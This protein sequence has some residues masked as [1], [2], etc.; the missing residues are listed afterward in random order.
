MKQWICADMTL[1][2]RFCPVFQ[3]E[4]DLALPVKSAILEICGLGLYDLRVNGQAPDDTL[5]NPGLTQYSVSVKYRRYELAS[6][7]RPGRNTLHVELGHGFFNENGGVW[8]WQTAA[9]RS[10]PRLS[11]ELTLTFPDSSKQSLCT[12]ESWLY[13]KDG[14]TVFNSVYA[15]ETHDF[16]LRTPLWKKSIPCDPPM[17]KPSLQQEPFIRKTEEYRPVSVEKTGKLRYL[18]TSPETVTGWARIRFSVPCTEGTEIT[19]TYGEQIAGSELLKCGKGYTSECSEWFP[20]VLQQDKCISGGEAFEFEPKFTY[21]GFRYL[22]VDGY[23]GPL[24]ADDIR[25]FRVAND[26]R[27]YT[28]FSCSDE[29]LNRLHAMMTRTLKNNFQFRPTDTPIWE[30]NGW[31]GDANCALGCMVNDF[32][33]EGYLRIFED[34]MADCFREFGDVP[35]MVPSAA[36]YTEN[37][38]V[39][40][41][42][43][44]FAA[45][46]LLTRYESY[47]YVRSLYPLLQAF[48]QKDIGDISALGWIWDRPSLA[49]WVSPSMDETTVEAADSEGPQICATGFV[50]GALRSMLR[51]G[52]MLGLEEDKT[53][54]AAMEKIAAAFEC[55]FWNEESGEY[56]T[57]AF[58]P[59]CGRTEYR[60]TSNLVPLWFG[61]VP[62]DRIPRVIRGVAEDIVRK[63]THLDTGCV[64]TRFLLPLLADNG[65]TELAMQLLS[66]RTY[67]SWG[68]WMELGADTM[69]EAWEPA[70]RS[71]D[72][73]FLGTADEFL[74]THLAG[75]RSVNCAEHLCEIRPFTDCGLERVSAETD[76]KYGL[77]CVSWTADEKGHCRIELSV[78]DGLTAHFVWNTREELLPGGHYHFES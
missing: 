56:R 1:E 33:M 54:T 11:A 57:S 9:W 44:I 22:E 68:Y 5:L 2:D 78:P 63:G 36:W 23:E 66:C 28:R 21:K 26:V 34:L 16:R 43:F 48:A 25:L 3:K 31:L 18:I 69:W 75:I 13:T 47:D 70:A 37:T 20:Y 6:L 53:Y 71:R 38:P 19:V 8:N 73:Y 67:P 29:R 55:R 30:K 52:S 35:V 27:E 74:L 40:N 17:G 10:V 58:K 62:Q 61:L 42:I 4:F 72:H 24:T 51:I 12:D 14:P 76:T 41:T 7:L 32:D 45:E 64:G 46:Y 50:Y 49:D 39:W 59:V 77:L 15:G 65:Y 60:Q